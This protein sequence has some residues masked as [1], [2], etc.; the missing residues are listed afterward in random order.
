MMKPLKSIFALL[1]SSILI[2]CFTAPTLS[3]SYVFYNP[4]VVNPESFS[5][6]LSAEFMCV[7][8]NNLYLGDGIVGLG[9]VD[10][11]DINN[12]K[13]VGNY[14]RP[15]NWR[16]LRDISAQ[17]DY[18]YI[19]S[20]NKFSI[21]DVSSRAF[22]Q[23]IGD[24]SWTTKTLVYD[25]LI[26][27]EPDEFNRFS[28]QGNMAYIASDL[29][30]NCIDITNPATPQ[31]IGSLTMVDNENM[32][33]LD[34]IHVNGSIAYV[35]NPTQIFCINISNPTSPLMLGHLEIGSN[36]ADL[37]V[38]DDEAYLLSYEFGLICVDISNP[39]SPS[40]VSKLSL[41]GISPS[42][43]LKGRIIIENK[44]AYI[45][46]DNDYGLICVDI[47]T[48]SDIKFVWKLLINS[49]AVSF[50]ISDGFVI[51]PEP[52]KGYNLNDISNSPTSK[53]LPIIS[54][55]TLILSIVLGILFITILYKENKDFFA[56]YIDKIRR[57]SSRV[58]TNVI[59]ITEK[60]KE[61]IEES[62]QKR[63]MK[64]FKR[65]RDL[66]MKFKQI[67]KLS[68]EIT[69][70]QASVMLDISERKLKK[71][72]QEWKEQI[73]F[74]VNAKMIIMDDM[75]AFFGDVDKEFIG[76][77]TRERTKDGKIE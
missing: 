45:S 76:W 50:S 40:L 61:K 66:L 53:S 29:G 30:L 68:S 11:T 57:V 52:L 75:K 59:E 23:I 60:G 51:F 18:V 13:Q 77:E 3:T 74:N 56:P 17:Q 42:E 10:I 46:R 35:S 54:L 22:P 67:M 19:L 72:L 28:I 8:D 32:I 33:Y 41:S 37:A 47:T 69:Y 44:R 5:S 9:I 73:P 14:Y 4:A 15:N 43:Y 34:N 24:I 7:Q 31:L 71:K 48:P 49:N 64:I 58:K 25:G 21:I 70:S 1:I 39:Q 16:S 12:P 65:D 6:D 2:Y 63:E 27:Y 38:S 36:I 20:K 26:Y 62:K 55:I